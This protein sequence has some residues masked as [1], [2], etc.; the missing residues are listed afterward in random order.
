MH[1][2]RSRPSGASTNSVDVRLVFVNRVLQLVQLGYDRMIPPAFRSKDEPEITG[3]LT[4]AI[5]AVLSGSA[6]AWMKFFFAQDEVPVNC[7]GR[8]GKHRKKVDI[9]IECSSHSPRLHYRFESKC[10]GPGHTIGKYLGREGLGRFL[11]GDY[12]SDEDQA[13]MLGYVQ[14]GDLDAWGHKIADELGKTPA[15]YFVDPTQPFAKRRTA[16]A[17]T[18]KYRSRHNRPTVG[19]TILIDHLLLLFQ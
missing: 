16:A 2:P 5:K 18:R 12:A 7:V 19:R 6:T 17:S 9:Y 11:R 15:G 4:V 10:L 14:S 8:K 1:S 3:E 13:G